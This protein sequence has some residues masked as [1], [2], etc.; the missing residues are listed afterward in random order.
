MRNSYLIRKLYLSFLIVSILSSLT[1]TVGILIDNIIVGMYLGDVSLG[2]MGIVGP[3]SLIFSA[4]GNICSGG[5]TARAA[6]ALGKGD[7]E[8]LY[9][10]FTV[11]VLFA[12][13][14]GFLI[15]ILGLLFTPQLAEL[16]GAKGELLEPSIQY[17]RGYFLGAVP[18]IMLTALSGF[19]K[20]DGSPR[21]PLICIIVMSSTN[22]ILDFLMIHA[23]HLGMF[24]MALATTISYLLAVL[25]ACTHFLK[26]HST[27]RLVVP[28]QMLGE[29]I[30][31]VTTGVP[32]AI[33][34]VCDTVKVMVLN[35]MLVLF[36]GVGAVT[37]LSIRTQAY[38]FFG[39]F[40]IGIAQASVP[41]TGLFYGEEDITALKD[42]LKNTL[43]I[44][45]FINVILAVL[46]FLT[47]PLFVGLMGVSEP[48]TK[49]MAVNA[50]RL[51][52]IGA[53][54]ALINY[55]F[56]SFYQSTKRIAMATMICVL[57]SLAYVLFVAVLLIGTLKEN[58][59]W[60]AFLAAEI[61]TIITTIAVIAY[62][63]RKIPEKITDIMLL[64]EDFG[65][66]E[67][68]RLEI[69]V[70]NDMEELVN[71]SAG[72]HKFGEGRNISQKLLKELALCIEEIGGNVIHHAF[73]PGEKK[74]FD[75]MILD[76]KDL[77]IVR[78]RDNGAAFNP[79]NYCDDYDMK[80]EKY[81]LQLIRSMAD[82]MKYKRTLEMNNIIITFK[83]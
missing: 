35:H 26:K 75:I 39:A 43:K 13:V 4:I 5:G 66:R 18:T 52:A 25:I 32:T 55:I 40:M 14:G 60:L 20:I 30:Q 31:M 44:G 3:I 37:A 59:V 24:G 2:A 65:S 15:T 53:P 83:K 61:L 23:F 56:M 10:I 33:S 34:R 76:K 79:V 12:A 78:L 54:F 50:V 67:E 36:V 45:L 19:V 6:Q 77:L 17:L 1:A 57:Q 81:G 68:D 48:E 16:L 74:W 49:K 80:K 63:C 29:W 46:L 8:G 69:S 42:T 27:L 9:R 73:R 58:G 21:L 47:A 28:K 82:D 72:I 64:K 70:G 51:F 41:L 62:H 71:I 11:T 22:I 7:G 38:S